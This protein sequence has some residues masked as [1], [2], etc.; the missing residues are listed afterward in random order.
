M[1]TLFSQQMQAG[2]LFYKH[3][4]GVSDRSGKEFH[5]FHEIVLFLGGKATF[6]S[7]QIH[8]EILPNTLILIP[9]ESYHQFII[10]GDPN[11]YYRCVL[12]FADSEELQSL[13]GC[14]TDIIFA[15][16]T[17]KLLSYFE[18][19][20]TL[21]KTAAP[22][23]G[24]VLKSVLVLLLNELHLQKAST[25][26]RQSQHP[27]VEDILSYISENMQRTLS[28]EIL[29]KK[30][31]LSPSSISHL[32]KKEM[33]IPLHQF[34]LKKRLI[35]AYHKIAAG[36]APSLVAAACGF[37]DYSGFYKQYKKMF[38]HSPSKKDDIFY[39]TNKEVPL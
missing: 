38:G 27:V 1:Y 17:G 15:E 7:E 37:H 5:T 33:K 24:L 28:V 25:Q 16:A 4:R 8:T 11:S 13:M 19:L 23:Q 3:A 30:Y 2:N 9:K 20:N 39:E 34:I 22:H 26:Q 31:H 32:F 12:H 18:T 29:A 21:A 14:M 6:I 36:E 35:T 10:H